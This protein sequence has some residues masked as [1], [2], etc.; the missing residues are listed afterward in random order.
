[1]NATTSVG[2]LGEPD[3]RSRK[4]AIGDLV[5]DTTMD[6]S[7]SKEGCSFKR[8]GQCIKHAVI[9]T[10]NITTWHEWTK[11]KNGLYGNVKRQKTSYVCHFSRG[12]NSNYG[13]LETDSRSSGVAES[14]SSNSSLEMGMP[15]NTSALGGISEYS[16][17][18]TFSGISGVDNNWPGCDKSESQRI[19]SNMKES[20]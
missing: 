11:T 3:K 13:H 16:D 19:R 5:A 9:G 6:S 12:A 14:N 18:T 7:T 10:K 8:G 2:I 20:V 17:N 15:T 1:M 4:P